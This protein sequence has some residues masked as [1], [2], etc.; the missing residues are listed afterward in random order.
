LGNFFAE[1]LA[2]FT[3]IAAIYTDKIYP[4]LVLKKIAPIAEDW[5]K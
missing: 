5:R 1:K 2:I 3:K 4:N